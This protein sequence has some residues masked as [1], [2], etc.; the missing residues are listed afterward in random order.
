MSASGQQRTC[1]F[2]IAMSA[3]PPQADIPR[4]DLDVCFGPKADIVRTDKLAFVIAS[5]HPK[6][7]FADEP[8]DT[9][10]KATFPF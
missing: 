9:P 10:V 2:E 5:S 7:D 6:C 3:L 4:R 8:L 1:R